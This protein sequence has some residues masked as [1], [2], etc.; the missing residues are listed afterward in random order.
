MEPTENAV[1]QPTVTIDGTQ[2]LVESLP[3]RAKYSLNQI[4]SIQAKQNNLRAELDQLEMA[5]NGFLELIR[6]DIA[7]MAIDDE[8]DDDLE[9]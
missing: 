1:T 7:E 4:Q 3:D 5:T 6:Q 8:D 9:E 2:Y